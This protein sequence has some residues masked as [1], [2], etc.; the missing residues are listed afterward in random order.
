MA[1]IDTRLSECVAYGFT[2]GP[3]YR[4]LVVDYDNG[5]E[6][7]NA[8]WQY[9]KHLYSCQYMNLRPEAQSELLAA[10]HAC[11]GRLH[12]FRFKDWNDYEGVTQPFVQIN[13]VWQM[14]KQYTLG[15]ET[16]NRPIQAPV[17]GEIAL[18]GGSLSDLDFTTGIYDGDATGLTWT[19]EFDVWA[20]F[21]SDYN[22]FAIGSWNAHTA[23]VE[24]QEVRRRIA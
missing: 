5:W 12:A 24:I 3:D 18:S 9:P 7:R 2:G 10:F 14:V 22:A 21:A 15:S 1:Y 13:G 11:R 19:G 23:D 6:Q 16:T 17:E 20:R 8:Q 4:T